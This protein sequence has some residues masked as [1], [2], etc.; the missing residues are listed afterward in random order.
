ML[1]V[2]GGG[3]EGAREGW[4]EGGTGV[5]NL[6]VILEF[7][8]LFLPL[9]IVGHHHGERAEESLEVVG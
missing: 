1:H 6:T 2:R 8:P 5:E 9:T 4:G 7:T 3:G